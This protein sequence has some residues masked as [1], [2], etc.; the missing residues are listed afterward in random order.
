M[1]LGLDIQPILVI[2][3]EGVESVAV[4]VRNPEWLPILDG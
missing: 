1:Q 3:R 2:P 4:P